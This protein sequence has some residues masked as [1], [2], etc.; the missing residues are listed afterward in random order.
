MDFA[1]TET[2]L[3]N[4]CFRFL[5][6]QRLQAKAVDGVSC[7][8]KECEGMKTKKKISKLFLDRDLFKRMYPNWLNSPST[9]IEMQ[10]ITY[11]IFEDYERKIYSTILTT[12]LKKDY[13]FRI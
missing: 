6:T 3:P 4:W 13:G 7:L 9:T 1:S 2:L 10:E 5:F 12:Q 11:T 8:E